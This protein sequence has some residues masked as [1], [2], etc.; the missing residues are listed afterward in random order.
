MQAAAHHIWQEATQDGATGIIVH[1]GNHCCPMAIIQA[2][3]VI[4]VLVKERPSFWSHPRVIF[5]PLA[6]GEAVNQ[7]PLGAMLP[8]FYLEP[9]RRLRTEAIGRYWS[10]VGRLKP[11]LLLP[12]LGANRLKCL[13]DIA[14][15]PLH[16]GQYLYH[17]MEMIGHT[18]PRQ[19]LHLMA[20]TGLVLGDALPI[21]LHRFAQRGQLHRR[22]SRIV[23]ESCQ[24][25]PTL[26][27]HQRN[28]ISAHP[29]VIE[30]WV[31]RA[32]GAFYFTH[33]P[34]L[35]TLSPRTSPSGTSLCTT[36]RTDR[37]HVAYLGRPD[38]R[39]H[40]HPRDRGR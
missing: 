18:Q 7:G 33:Y 4:V 24:Q 5:S 31:A 9:N 13:H 39:L 34:L 2:D 35:S 23:V 21:L 14:Q 38:Y 1:V 17:A 3:R 12:M 27:H 40:R 30:A 10:I 37:G 19:Y 22:M 15:T 26:T 11:L 25:W 6:L 32:I 8:G 28:E 16:R 29:I 20:V 36:P